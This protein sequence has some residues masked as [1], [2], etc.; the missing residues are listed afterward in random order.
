MRNP[1]PDLDEAQLAQLTAQARK[2]DLAALDYGI[3]TELALR[4][5]LT[6][7]E[8]PRQWAWKESH[9]L[10]EIWREKDRGPFPWPRRIVA[11]AIELLLEKE[12]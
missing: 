12:E 8:T 10:Q 5:C 4:L 1:I 11:R 7:E 6:W 9:V 2:V 3:P